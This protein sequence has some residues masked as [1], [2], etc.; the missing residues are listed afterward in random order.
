[1]TDMGKMKRRAIYGVAIG[2]AIGVPYEFRQRDSFVCTDMDGFGT[3]K[4]PAGTWSDDTSMTL[5]TED[6]IKARGGKI[7]VKDMSTRFSG[8][9]FFDD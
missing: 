8:W 3:Y 4:K 5:A 7:D 6:S 2:D 1:M 9:Y